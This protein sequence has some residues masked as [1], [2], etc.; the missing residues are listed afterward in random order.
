MMRTSIDSQFIVRYLTNDLTVEEKQVFER[1]LSE[2]DS[3]KEEVAGIAL[4][5]D[6]LG[7]HADVEPGAENKA[8]EQLEGRLNG[9]EDGTAV[10]PSLSKSVSG[11]L[12]RLTV[13]R[14]AA[15]V[16]LIAG[17]VM[18]AVVLTRMSARHERPQ[19]AAMHEVSTKNGQRLTVLFPDGSVAYLNAGSRLRY[20]DS[21]GAAE[22]H[23]EMEGEAYF[24]VAA[25]SER[26]F[27]VTTGA[28][29]TEV[30]GTEF[31]LRWRDS[32][33][34]LTVAK[35]I[36]RSSD[37]VSTYRLVKG[38]HIT[39]DASRSSFSPVSRANI[40][41]SLAWKENKLAFSHATLE[42][43]MKELELWYDV[44]VVFASS[45]ATKKTLTG[46]F[47]TES[48]DEILSN[49]SFALNVRVVRNGKT[50]HVK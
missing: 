4:L 2:S 40:G 30:V 21:F 25:D 23:I 3:H 34:S 27:R 10:P 26:P 38:D 47:R 44:H 12:Q 46:V 20:P 43:A 48:L 15:A 50:V 19:T 9:V 39:Y 42:Q 31:N 13:V 14:A 17:I 36:V 18:S 45:S 5:W 8:W 32:L 11:A 22:R 28:A 1:W 41:Y 49:I 35:G 7:K 37:R 16:I 29:T 33:Y 6:E 24:T